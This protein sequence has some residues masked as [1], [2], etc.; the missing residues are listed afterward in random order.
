M[1]LQYANMALLHELTP[2]KLMLSRAGYHLE[3]GDFPRSYKAT[4][5]IHA[6]EPVIKL[7]DLL[8]PF[9]FWYRASRYHVT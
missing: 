2:E 3:T 8:P 9:N 7:S 4:L 6:R 5:W 1:S